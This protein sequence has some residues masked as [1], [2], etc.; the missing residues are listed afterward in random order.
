VQLAVLAGALATGLGAHAVVDRRTRDVAALGERFDVV[1]DAAGTLPFLPHLLTGDGVQVSVRPLSPDVLRAALRPRRGPRFTAVRTAP[2]SH[3]LAR[4]AALV[5]AGRLR[6]VV[7]G[8]Y[9]MAEVADAHRHAESG[10]R[11]KVVLT[12]A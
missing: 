10:V 2:R 12:L 8:S 3:D 1:L 4:L 11:G 6:A 7:D 5:D 9:P